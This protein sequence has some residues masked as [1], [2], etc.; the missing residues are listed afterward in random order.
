MDDLITMYPEL[1]LEMLKLEIDWEF[2]EFEERLA[3]ILE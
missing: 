2:Q 1:A 3:K